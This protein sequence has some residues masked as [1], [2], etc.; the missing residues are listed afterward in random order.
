MPLDLS[1]KLLYIER[2]NSSSKTAISNARDRQTVIQSTIQGT[3][4]AQ[5]H[6]SAHT[7]L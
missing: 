5:E 3:P 4:T 2:C 7:H 6:A 1:C